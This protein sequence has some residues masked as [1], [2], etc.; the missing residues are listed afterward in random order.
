MAAGKLKVS[1]KVLEKYSQQNMDT[2]VGAYTKEA[3]GV[4]SRYSNMKKNMEDFNKNAKKED[5]TQFFDQLYGKLTTNIATYKSEKHKIGL[6]KDAVSGKGLVMEVEDDYDAL[7]TVM[8]KVFSV[9][10]GDGKAP[11]AESSGGLV[12]KAY[13]ITAEY[14]A[15]KKERDVNKAIYNRIKRR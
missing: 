6:E 3:L 10:Q 5:I 4:G 7:M 8:G 15:F 13:K 1:S 12:S 2:K 9:A 11:T 14:D